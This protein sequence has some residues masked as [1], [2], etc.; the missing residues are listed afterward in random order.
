MKKLF[1]FTSLLCLFAVGCT[2]DPREA[3]IN[4]VLSALNNSSSHL[5]IVKKKLT[6]VLKK[7]KISADD[8]Q[9]ITNTIEKIKEEGERL[10]KFN[11]AIVADTEKKPI[12]KEEMAKYESKFKEQVQSAVASLREETRAVIELVDELERKSKKQAEDLR[13]ALRAANAE[14]QQMASRK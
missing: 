3:H 11:R 12:P 14:F 10:Q 7:E 5:S 8:M 9:E 13:K 4:N 2:G 6:D 1:A